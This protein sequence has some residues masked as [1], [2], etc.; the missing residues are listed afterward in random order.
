MAK[1]KKGSR[2]ATHA[3]KKQKI[4]NDKSCGSSRGGGGEEELEEEDVVMVEQQQQQHSADAVEGMMIKTTVEEEDVVM[5][6]QQQ[7]QQHSADAVEG[8]MIKMT[9][10]AFLAGEDEKGDG[11]FVQACCQ[12]VFDA[13]PACT[14]DQSDE[15]D[16][17]AYFNHLSRNDLF[18]KQLEMIETISEGI[19]IQLFPPLK[20]GEHNDEDEDEL[21]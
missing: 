1:K 21:L 2:N 14:F 18:G 4:N 17:I 20:V 9:V 6:E 19:C 10:A 15:N 16:V 12:S 7:Q 8:M 3:S 11:T 5:V 13:S